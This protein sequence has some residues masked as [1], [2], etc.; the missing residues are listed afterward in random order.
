[1]CR[2]LCRLPFFDFE[3]GGERADSVYPLLKEYMVCGDHVPASV[4]RIF[5]FC[6]VS[7][8][9]HFDYLVKVLHPKNKLQAKST[10][11]CRV[12]QSKEKM[13]RI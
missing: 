12:L 3:E 9:Y 13:S 5:Y 1:M 6:F 2:L 8:C 7:L 4:H 11:R 10:I